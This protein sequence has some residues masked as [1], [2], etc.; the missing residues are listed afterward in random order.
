M[1]RI[2]QS[3]RLQSCTLRLSCCT[4]DPSTVVLAHLPC[5]DKST[6]KKGPNHYAC[7]A[8]SSCHDVIDRRKDSG[9]MRVE[10]LERMLAGL[11]ETQRELIRLGLIE[12]H[13]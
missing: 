10:I 4:H 5:S 7:Y 1:S 9:M 6:G 3:A 13:E 2:R 11:Y 8:C 12:I